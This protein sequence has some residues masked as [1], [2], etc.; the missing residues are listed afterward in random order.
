MGAKQRRQLARARQQ[1]KHAE[2]RHR[3][4][5]RDFERISIR[6][7][8]ETINEL[9]QYKAREAALANNKPASRFVDGNH[10]FLFQIK[11]NRFTLLQMDDTTRAML[12]QRFADE[13]L[14]LMNSTVPLL[15]DGLP[16]RHT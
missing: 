5:M 11:I 6:H 13:L 1:A 14:A 8:L 4:Q 7:G 2:A 10:E 16:R 3:E 12:V 9:N 15:P